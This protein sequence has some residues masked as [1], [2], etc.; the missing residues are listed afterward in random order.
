M[1]KT[2]FLLLLST[3]ASLSYGQII[4]MQSQSYVVHNESGETDTITCLVYKIENKSSSPQVIMFTEDNICE[5]SMEKLI[6]KKCFRRYGDFSLSSWAWENIINMSKHVLI[7]DC[8]VKIVKPAEEFTITV[9]IKNRDENLIDSMFRNH[10]L[11][12]TASQIEKVVSGL[13]RGLE[14]N[15][16]DYPYSSLTIT[17]DQL[18][19][20][21]QQESEISGDSK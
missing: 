4:A 7:P 15:H 12:C 3:L 14:Y 20:L 1:K 18:K 16:V 11:V 9:L 19:R 13:L 5:M 17:W 8:F 6:T 21:N 2:I 10:L